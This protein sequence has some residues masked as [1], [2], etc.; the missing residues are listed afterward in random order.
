MKPAGFH[1]CSLDFPAGSYPQMNP[2]RIISPY[3]FYIYFISPLTHGA[4]PFFRS[5]QFCSYSRTSQRFMEPKGSSPCSR[6]PSNSP[7]PDP[8]QSNPYHPILSLQDQ[9]QYYPPIYAEVLLMVSLHL[10]FP[11]KSYMASSSAP[12][13]LHALPI[14]SSLTWR[15]VHVLKLLIMQLSPTSCHF[16]SLRFLSSHVKLYSLRVSCTTFCT[17]F[18][19]P[20]CSLH[21]RPISSW[22]YY[23]N[24]IWWR[25][26]IRKF[27][28]MQIPPHS[29]YVQ[30]FSSAHCSQTSQIYVSSDRDQN[31]YPYKTRDKI[32]IL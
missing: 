30:I 31:S 27:L 1:T 17:H 20:R 4:E 2:V 13:V 25:V 16:I 21:S 9:S 29:S 12:R 28:A 7:Y 5:R 6:Q 11:P 22:F 15:R 23:P 26:E 18:S 32:I 8:D 19:S 24:I 14:T 10:A 3:F